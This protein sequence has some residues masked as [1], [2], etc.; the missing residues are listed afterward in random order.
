MTTDAMLDDLQAIARGAVPEI[1][2][3]GLIEYSVFAVDGDNYDLRPTDPEKYPPIPNCAVKP[4]IPGL[5]ATM[6]V[7]ALVYVSFANGN[8]AKPVIIAVAGPDDQGFTPVSLSLSASGTVKIDGA[9]VELGN[10]GVPGIGSPP[11]R[12]GDTVQIG[13]TSGPISIVTPFGTPPTPTKVLV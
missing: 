12:V 10:G 4:G 3:L 13:T 7:G 5:R 2:I 1:D 6:A 9:S 11:I 8:A